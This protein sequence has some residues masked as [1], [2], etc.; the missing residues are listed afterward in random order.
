MFEQFKTCAEIGINVLRG[1]AFADT[2]VPKKRNAITAVISR[3][4]GSIDKLPVSFNSRVDAG[5]NWQAGIMGSATANPANY[6]ALSSVVLTPAKADTT[7]ASEIVANGCARALAT[8]QNY[9]APSALG[10]AASYQLTKTF[11]ATGAQTVNSAAIFNASSAG[12]LFVEANL[13]SPATLASGDSLTVSW[14]IN[15]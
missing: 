14:S 8:Y 2:L 11:T 7:L 12:V 6:I 9:T 15:L 4:D 5:A 3:A 10:G 13:A 1:R